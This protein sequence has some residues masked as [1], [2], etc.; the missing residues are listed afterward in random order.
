MGEEE[1]SEEHL[2][3]PRN[4]VTNIEKGEAN[5][6][7]DYDVIDG[8]E[9]ENNTPIEDVVSL[10]EDGEEPKK[11]PEEVIEVKKADLPPQSAAPVKLPEG[12]TDI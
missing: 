1:L 6:D 2:R 12:V 11:N 8:V 7:D 5:L 10:D 9:M 3:K 4:G